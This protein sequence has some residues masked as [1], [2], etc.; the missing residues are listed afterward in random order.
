ECIAPWLGLPQLPLVR[1]PEPADEDERNGL[2]WK[3]RPLISWAAGRPFAWVDDEITDADAARVE[4]H[5]SGP[6]LLRRIDPRRGITDE[7]YAVIEAWLRMQR[8]H[9]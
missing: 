5:H 8:G 4:A 7:D 2:H 3:T 6:A 9:V 1:W